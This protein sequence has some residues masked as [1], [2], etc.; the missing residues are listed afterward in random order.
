MKDN[1]DLIGYKQLFETANSP[2]D[3]TNSIYLFYIELAKITELEDQL[4]DKNLD[5]SEHK[6]IISKTP[7]SYLLHASIQDIPNIVRDFLL[8]NLA[9]YQIV[10]LSKIRAVI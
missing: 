8:N 2:S 6:G 1:H 10:R 7:N 3:Y 5:H 4:V 9:V